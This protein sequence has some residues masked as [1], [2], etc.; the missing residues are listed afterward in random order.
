MHKIQRWASD[1]IV[2]I[3]PINTRQHHLQNGNGNSNMNS[4]IISLPQSEGADGMTKSQHQHILM[5]M[6]P[7]DKSKR[8]I[9]IY[10]ASRPG[11]G[12]AQ[13]IRS[14]ASETK[15]NGSTKSSRGRESVFV[16]LNVQLP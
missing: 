8:S 12:D 13:S 4:S 16:K 3:F 5:S 15:L 7:G 6:I 10:P 1:Q 9:R 2:E 14:K 11:T